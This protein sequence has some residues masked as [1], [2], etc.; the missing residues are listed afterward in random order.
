V[1]ERGALKVC[2]F[3]GSLES[4]Y[5]QNKKFLDKITD[6]SWGVVEQ[7]HF[8][9]A[10]K[11]EFENDRLKFFSTVVEC[12]EE[13]GSNVLILSSV[14]QYIEEPYELLDNILKNNFKYILID[15][16]PF[17]KGPERIT[18]QVVPPYV[19]DASYPCHFFDESIFMQYFSKK[20]YFPIE[21][22]I[23]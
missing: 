5:Y 10:G 8:V 3:G 17:S 1:L 21:S 15:R 2:D 14:L 12:I 4:T 20:E 16:T 19:Y 6:V 23:C 7:R 11:E 9:D 13:E 18:L 22:F